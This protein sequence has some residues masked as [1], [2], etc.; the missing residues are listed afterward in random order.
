MLLFALGLMAAAASPAP[1]KEE[2]A[3]GAPS[4]KM[5]QLAQNCDAHKFETIIEV[6]VE[7]QPKRSRMKLCGTEGQSD[8]DWIKTLKDA[9]SK[10][11]AN[12]QMPP[13]V[14]QQI[15]TALNGEIARLGGQAVSVAPQIKSAPAAA[16]PPPRQLAPKASTQPEYSELPSLPTAP[17]PPVHV[18]GGAGV[19][20]AAAMPSLPRPRMSFSCFTPGDIGG[21]GPCTGFARD[22]MVT[23]RASEDLPSGTS[24]RFVRDGDPRADV[25]LAQLKRGKTMQFALPREVCS[26]AVGGSLK[27]TIVRSG[28][29]VGDEGPFNL[30]C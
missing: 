10:T 20:A 30:R 28:Q 2:P 18:L 25:E 14:R 8:A 23:V 21:D 12:L 9:V 11:E 29:E 15:V 17:P 7:G 13:A 27:L 19:G 3:N 26:H 5:E 6:T 4:E 1:A 16:L 22:T 24:L